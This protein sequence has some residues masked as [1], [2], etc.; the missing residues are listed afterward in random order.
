MNV[1]EG[2]EK[3][4]SLL[5][6]DLEGIFLKVNTGVIGPLEEIRKNIA[7][8]EFHPVSVGEF[9]AST[10]Q[11]LASVLDKLHENEL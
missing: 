9:L 7:T 2:L 5:D 11:K 6:S 1:V 10:D 4:R 3:K 8:L